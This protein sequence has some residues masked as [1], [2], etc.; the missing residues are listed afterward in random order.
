LIYLVDENDNNLEYWEGPEA[1][2]PV[3]ELTNQKFKK[4]PQGYVWVIGDNRELSWYGLL[5]IKNIKGLV[6]L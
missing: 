2:Q 4:I 6:I 1:G 5:K 3:T